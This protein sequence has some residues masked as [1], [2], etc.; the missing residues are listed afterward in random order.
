MKKSYIAEVALAEAVVFL[1]LWLWRPYLAFLLTLIFVGIVVEVLAVALIAELI[2]RTRITR[3]YFWWMSVSVVVPLLIAAV[4][5]WSG[6]GTV[7]EWMQ[8]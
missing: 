4:F 8:W 5:V 6:G 2:E 1:L 3:A 7:R